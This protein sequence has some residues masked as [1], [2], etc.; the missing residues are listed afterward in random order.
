V[1]RFGGDR[2]R[3]HLLRG[4]SAGFA[5]NLKWTSLRRRVRCR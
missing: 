3:R 5:V 1:P 4:P 2:R